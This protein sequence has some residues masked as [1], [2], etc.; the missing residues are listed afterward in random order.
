MPD[1]TIT[2]KA[3][4]RLLLWLNPDRDRGA[5]EYERLRRKL[6]LLFASRGGSAPEEMADDCMNRVM[7]KLPEIEGEYQGPPDAY[8][9]GVA[10]IIILEWD[11]KNR[12]IEIPPI[13]GIS[14]ETEEY[15]ACLDLCLDKL[16]EQG[17]EVVTEYYQ[18]E[19]QARIDRRAELARRFNITANALRI[20]AHHIRLQ[21]ERCVLECVHQR[22]FA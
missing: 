4:D 12:P 14:P 21:L 11:R 15:L 22:A 5:E 20:R 8:F 1:W 17:R 16:P 7:R 2:Q 10:R 3:F 13:K 6:I 9:F 19:K 18:E